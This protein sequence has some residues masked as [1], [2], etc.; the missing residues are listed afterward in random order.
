MF[1]LLIPFVGKSVS[2]SSVQ[3]LAF[4]LLRLE[5]SQIATGVGWKLD[6]DVLAVSDSVANRLRFAL[7]Q[8]SS[9]TL[10]LALSLSSSSSSSSESPAHTSGTSNKSVTTFLD[11][12]F[13][14]DV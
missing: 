10:L 11:E 3:L 14:V 5:L 12:E 6:I 4:L 9:E 2:M 7:L 13:F 8:T 1:N